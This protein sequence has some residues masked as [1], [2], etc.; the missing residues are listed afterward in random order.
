MPSL[1]T[2]RAENPLTGAGI[3]RYFNEERGIKIDP[4]TFVGITAAFI[5]AEIL[6]KLA[7]F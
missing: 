4:T 6:L 3:I 5:I 7:N 1:K 2:E